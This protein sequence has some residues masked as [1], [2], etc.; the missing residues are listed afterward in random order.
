[1]TLS[2]RNER[3]RHGTR[4]CVVG[5]AALQVTCSKMKYWWVLAS[6]GGVNCWPDASSSQS[7]ARKTES[8][9]IAAKARRKKC[10][11]PL[12]YQDKV[13]SK[14]MFRLHKQIHGAATGLCLG[15]TL[16][17]GPTIARQS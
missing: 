3:S 9:L 8:W 7:D 11:L 16:P 1:M 15:K 5:Q 12:Q 10:R 4:Y 17:W 14:Y 2:D 13:P 6:M